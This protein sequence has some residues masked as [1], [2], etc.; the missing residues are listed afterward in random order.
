[1]LSNANNCF[2]CVS[3]P[4]QFTLHSAFP[5]PFNGAVNFKFFMPEN[6]SVTFKI[7]D[8]NGRVITEKLILPGIKGEYSVNWNGKDMYGNNKSSGIYFYQFISKSSIYQD[9]ITYLK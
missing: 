3:G 7:F 6:E 9:K 5:N 1:M 4:N 2:D 8:L